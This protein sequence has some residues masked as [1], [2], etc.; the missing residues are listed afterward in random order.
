MRYG[1]ILTWIE[2]AT[3]DRIR[4]RVREFERTGDVVCGGFFFSG[5]MMMSEERGQWECNIS[6]LLGFLDPR[7]F[8]FEAIAMACSFMSAF[9][10]R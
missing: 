6:E 10:T 7:L 3:T 5:G 9:N 2:I 1:K 4:C 8:E